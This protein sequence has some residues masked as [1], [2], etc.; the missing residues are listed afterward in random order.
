MLIYRG[1]WTEPRLK[2]KEKDEES[3]T[4]QE[5]HGQSRE[6]KEQDKY[7]LKT[8][9]SPP[10][11]NKT[12][13]PIDLQLPNNCPIGARVGLLRNSSNLLQFWLQTEQYNKEREDTERDNSVTLLPSTRLNMKQRI[14][15]MKKLMDTKIV[16]PL[17]RTLRI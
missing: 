15:V 16:L 6:N 1:F 7:P 5:S 2:I 10:W 14:N 9:F 12:L 17:A 4:K 13:K 3:E 11:I 8:F